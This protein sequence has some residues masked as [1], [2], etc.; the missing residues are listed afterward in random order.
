VGSIQLIGSIASIN[1]NVL[2]SLTEKTGA[3]KV[4]LV[5]GDHG[6]Q[7]K[8]DKNQT[9]LAA[10]LHLTKAGIENKAGGS[11]T[12]LVGG[13]H[14]QKL[15]GSYA[16][17]APIITLLGAVGVFKGGGSELKLGGGPIVLKGD[18]I[19]VKGGLIVKMSGSMK[20]GS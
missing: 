19:A 3:V 8:G 11:V 14:Y 4:Q 20:L 1:D 15:D 12:N 6:E 2:G 17:K 18:K 16:V 10:E 13:L 9:Y 5:N 7:I